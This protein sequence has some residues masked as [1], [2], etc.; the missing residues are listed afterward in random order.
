LADLEVLD[1]VVAVDTIDWIYNRD[2]RARYSEGELVQVGS[3]ADIDVERIISLEPDVV[4]MSPAGPDDPA[5]ERLHGAGIPAL[6]YADWR[7]QSPLGRAEWV[8]LIG[9]LTGRLDRAT[10]VFSDR[11]Q[12][13]ES[14]VSATSDMPTDERPTIMA[15]A[16]WQGNWPVPRGESYVAQLFADA[17]GAYLWADTSGAGSLFLDLEAVL[18]RAAGAE[19]WINLNAG[20]DSRSDVTDLDPRL[21][22]FAAFRTGRLYHYNGRVR[23]SGANDFWESGATRPDLVIADLISIL[24]PELAPDHEAVYYRRLRR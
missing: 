1:R 15:N 4:L 24:H 20:W 22:A 19:Y 6:A 16:P 18:A 17:G 14:L 9:V 10:E 2:I 5:I 3:G 12:R 7:E 13:Y 11:V 8:K 23:E 21:A